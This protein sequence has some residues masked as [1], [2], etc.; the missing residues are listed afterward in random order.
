MRYNSQKSRNLDSISRTKFLLI[1][2]STVFVYSYKLCFER[3]LRN[4]SCLQISKA[5]INFVFELTSKTFAG[6][7]NSIV[8]DFII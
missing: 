4:R 2:N 1:T 8:F 7:R 5:D 3:H 6:N